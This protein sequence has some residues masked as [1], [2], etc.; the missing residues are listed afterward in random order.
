MEWRDLYPIFYLF[1]ALLHLLPCVGQG[2]ETKDVAP[3]AYGGAGG[4]NFCGILGVEATGRY[5]GA[6]R[7]DLR[8]D[9]D[10]NG[11][12]GLGRNAW[13]KGRDDGYT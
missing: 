10:G 12:H 6:R 1:D 4:G 13:S 7:Y 3:L 9:T 8:T 2:D 11:C 5:G